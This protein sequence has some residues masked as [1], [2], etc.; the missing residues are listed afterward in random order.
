MIFRRNCSSPVP[1]PQFE[2]LRELR[3]S[4]KR[5]KCESKASVRVGGFADVF[6]SA[7]ML[8]LGQGLPLRLGVQHRFFVEG[9]REE[10]PPLYLP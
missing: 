2:P 9:F 6:G 5:R 4:G 1:G 8:P 10:A 7:G 3:C